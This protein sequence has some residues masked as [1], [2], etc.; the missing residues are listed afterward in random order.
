MAQIVGVHGIA[1]E[2]TGG[3][4][5]GPVWLGALRD[6]LAAA[7]HRARAEELADRDLRI[8]FFGDLF[9]RAGSMAA[10]DPPYSPA[11]LRPGPER[12]LLAELYRAAVAQEPALGPP[13]GAMAPGSVPVQ[14]MAE[15]LLRSATF[16]GVAQRAFIGSL[17]QVTRYL[18][19]PA[20]RERVLALVHERL[21]GGTRVL[22]GHSLGSV[23][24]YEYLCQY[25]PPSVELLVT[26]GCPLGIPNV[27][28][29]RLTPAPAGGQG[30]W[31]GLIAGWANV[32]DP[33]DVVALRKKLAGLFPG[34]PGRAVSDRLVNNGGKPHDVRRYLSARETGSALGDVLG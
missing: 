13:S 21:D 14:V 25:R 5:L 32:A 12:E 2:F 31:P 23:I 18:G 4:E 17:K 3:F 1:Q 26:L 29:D 15:R 11:D 7:G 20:T 9:R 22:I 16:A 33:D 10:Q 28:F 30:A 27:V 8:A 34:P 6:G 24:A 19:D